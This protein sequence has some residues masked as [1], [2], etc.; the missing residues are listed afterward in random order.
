MSIAGKW[1]EDPRGETEVNLWRF[2]FTVNRSF[3]GYPS[4]PITIPRSQVD[5]DLVSVT[6]RAAIVYPR[7]E[8]LHGRI[9]HS[10]AKRG[11]YYQIVHAVDSRIPKY[12]RRDDLVVIE[13]SQSN[14][15]TTIA[16][17]MGKPSGV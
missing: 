2:R 4:H 8:K 7:G 5:Y 3:L 15:K 17:S 16:I 13:G 12:L 9:Y 6:E 14:R 10:T 1:A 11:P